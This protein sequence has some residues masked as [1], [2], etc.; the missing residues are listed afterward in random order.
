V[1]AVLVALKRLL[2]VFKASNSTNALLKHS[3]ER[4]GTA[5]L[6]LCGAVLLL[7]TLLAAA[8]TL[9]RRPPLSARARRWV[10]T[11]LAV[12]AVAVTAAGGTVATHG[13]PFRFIERQWNGFS[14]AQTNYSS[15]SHFL[16]VGSGRYDFWR[17]ALDAFVSHPIGGL[18]QD[19]FG[20]YYLLHGH[21]GEEPSW[22]HSIELR[23][24]ASTGIVG[25]ALFAVFLVAAVRAALRARSREGLTATVAGAALLPLVVWMIHGSIDWFWE[26]PALSGPSLG[27]LAVAIGLGEQQ[28]G[29]LMSVEP[30]EPV[31]L[32]WKPVAVAVP[33]FLVCVTVLGFSYLS[34]RE[35]SIATNI[36]SRDPNEALHD[37]KLAADLNPLSSI[38]G[39]L[40]GTVALHEHEYAI[41][42]RRFEQ[43]L[44]NQPE[45]WFSWLG[46]GLAA[47]AL[48]QRTTAH[49]DFADAD[50]IESHQ[51]AVTTALK[52]VYSAHPLSPSAALDMIVVVG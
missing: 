19:N 20:D 34:A 40:A 23:L 14:H 38:A 49:R 50:R 10:G 32:R 24:L 28:R 11:A 2:D 26:M 6:V 47:S 3:A 16:D 45:G 9:R 5:A 39:R 21:T 17:V 36:A 7:G 41:A 31:R 52:R 12:L 22:P 33:L 51:P 37:L 29:F 13:H 18:G 43:S 46:A 4:A 35:V 48:G 1:L 42:E 30:S 27:F 44:S 15:Q 25:F 8:E